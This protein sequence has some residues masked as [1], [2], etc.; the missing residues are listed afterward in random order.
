MESQVHGTT[1]SI[2]AP[3]SDEPSNAFRSKRRSLWLTLV[4]VLAG[5]QLAQE[6][7]GSVTTL[8][9]Q[10]LGLSPAQLS[11]LPIIGLF[12]AGLSSL[13]A[14]PIIDR[15]G[16]RRAL[17]IALVG[18]VLCQL[19]VGAF[20][21]PGSHPGALTEGTVAT[22][23]VLHI[24]L[25][26]DRLLLLHRIL[27]VA[28]HSCLAIGTVASLCIAANWSHSNERG[29]FIVVLLMSASVL[30]A[31]ARG[32]L[33]VWLATASWRL[34][35]LFALLALVVGWRLKNSPQEAGVELLADGKLACAENRS[36]L[37]SPQRDGRSILSF[38]TP[39][40][41]AA[42]VLCFS[43]VHCAI[44]AGTGWYHQQLGAGTFDDLYQQSVPFR[45][46]LGMPASAGSWGVLLVGYLSDRIAHR[47]RIHLLAALLI[48]QFAAV[49][50]YRQAAA[51]D[52][53]LACSMLVTMLLANAGLLLAAKIIPVDLGQRSAVATLL[54][55]SAFAQSA[56]DALA[57]RWLRHVWADT[58]DSVQLLDGMG[59][60]LKL[61]LGLATVG[62]AL[63]AA[64]LWEQSA[65]E[66]LTVGVSLP[67]QRAHQTQRFT[68]TRIWVLL[69][70]QTGMGTAAGVAWLASPAPLHPTVA[71]ELD[72]QTWPQTLVQARQ[73]FSTQIVTQEGYQSDGPAPEPPPGVLQRI[74][75]PS[76]VGPLSAYITPRPNDE[77]RHPAVVWAH[78]GFG[79]IGDFLWNSPY[80][81]DDQTAGA[82][83]AAGL[84]VMYPSW[85]GENG[86]P[87][88]FEMFYGEVDDFLAAADYLATLPWVDPSRIYLAGHSTGGTI[89]LLAAT[90]TDRFRAAFVFGGT[91]G[92]SEDPAEL[93]TLW[94]RQPA[95]P[96]EVDKKEEA[97]LRS[98]INFV[99]DIRRPT[100][101]FEG[102]DNAPSALPLLQAQASAAGAPLTVISVP[103]GDHWTILQPLTKLIADR[104]LLDTEPTCNIRITE[105]DAAAAFRRSFPE[106]AGGDRWN[107]AAVDWKPFSEGLKAARQLRR[108]I[109]LV[110]FTD[111]CRACSRYKRVF[112][113]PA[114][115]AESRKFVMI[116]VNQDREPEIGSRF[117]IDGQYIPRT[118]FLSSNGRLDKSLRA[119]G[120]PAS[121]SGLYNY[122]ERE[123]SALLSGMRAALAKL[124]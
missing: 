40:I 4:A 79:G 86:N 62:V 19:A 98:A 43:T 100:Y 1:N 18:T 72:P 9:T 11:A 70:V 26:A 53:L 21:R 58:H 5:L 32:P 109:C 82:F 47:S 22:L 74:S 16:G 124:R 106:L 91:F 105:L 68:T 66:D 48:G 112:H 87:G 8:L 88:K 95:V 34:A 56:G 24:A 55:L 78:G 51:H 116:R 20:V 23:P 36:T 80:P 96:F 107:D 104:I 57:G 54:G 35:A 42:C 46:T 122:D 85:R 89:A 25:S 49:L 3:L 7:V 121:S 76:S 37:G 118:L 30:Q 45:M 93:R 65:K 28:S 6:S 120:S 101:Y 13:F 52:W 50:A 27:W 44:K 110:I 113:D 60:W 64:L 102:S 81:D 103:G 63:G 77:Q 90:S 17:C 83:R 61:P 39:W 75:Y 10:L 69:F 94:Q 59:R 38:P 67:G 108:P 71:K 41:V 92:F 31:V 73:G 123:P 12:T 14:G 114:V 117:D 2:G 99:G 15:I 111:W 33:G 119:S 29:G 115:V 97:R 84:V